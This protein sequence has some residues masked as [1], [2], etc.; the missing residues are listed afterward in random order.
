VLTLSSVCNKKVALRDKAQGYLVCEPLTGIEPATISLVRG[1]LC[2]QQI[3]VALRDE[4]QGYFF[5]EPL[6][7]FEPT[8]ISGVNQELYPLSY[9]GT[10]FG[11]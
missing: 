8:T 10:Q 5:C 3:K 2:P 4:L 6:V 7:G 9:S 1:M 11:I